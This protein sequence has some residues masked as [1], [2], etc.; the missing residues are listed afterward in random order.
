MQAKD[1]MTT[2]VVTVTSESGV[3]EIAALLLKRNISAVPVVDAEGRILGIVS[4]GDL[5]HRPE[6]ETERP[7]SWWL[8]LMAD[9]Q[10][11]A[12]AYTKSHGRRADEIMTRNVIT[13]SE[14]TPVGEIAQIL[15]ERRI[16]RVPVVRDGKLVGIVSRANLLHGL[17][18]RKDRVAEAPSADDRT[19]REQI[20]AH[21]DDQGWVS[22]GGL[23]VIVSDGV[24][25]LWGWVESDQERKALIVAAE[26]VAGVRAVEDHL[27][28]AP[29]WAWGA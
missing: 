6:S 18:A 26:N 25:E 4:E 5:M 19:I 29:P 14:D 17:V 11:S 23:N 1:I 7:R 2:N 21:I 12:A 13:V 9:S 20:L 15:E 27:G 16:K 3:D 28:S 22:H 8:V 24:V 10:E